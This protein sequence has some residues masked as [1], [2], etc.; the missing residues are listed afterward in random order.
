[1]KPIYKILIGVIVGGI[2]LFSIYLAVTSQ[3][4]VA[5]PATVPITGP[6]LTV[7]AK[8]GSLPVS[9]F[10]KHPQ[11][12]LG[13]TTVIKQNDNYSIV[14]FPV[15]QSFLI[16]ILAQ[17]VQQNRD[18]AEQLLLSQLQVSEADAC[19]L[20][21]SLTVPAGVSEQLAGV[22]YGLSFCPNGKAFP[23]Q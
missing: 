13:A 12:V 17:P 10:T 7:P 3:K 22:D 6:T 1:M 15:D 16:T 14:Y 5:S 18:A 8:G 19:K 4:Q 23:S 20:A 2:F 11:E 21:V 9:D